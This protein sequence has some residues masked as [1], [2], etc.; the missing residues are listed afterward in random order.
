MLVVTATVTGCPDIK[1]VIPDAN[2]IP[3]AIETVC[4]ETQVGVPDMFADVGI[5]DN[6]TFCPDRFAVDAGF[7]VVKPDTT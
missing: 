5:P 3:D 4:P 7:I 6:T 1:T 2:H